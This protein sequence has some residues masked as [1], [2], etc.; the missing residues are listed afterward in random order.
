MHRRLKKQTQCK[1]QIV[2]NKHCL[3]MTSA[4]EADRHHLFDAVL[5]EVFTVADHLRTAGSA[6]PQ[7]LPSVKT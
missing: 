5:E 7:V 6:Y 1:L 2:F 4:G 3:H